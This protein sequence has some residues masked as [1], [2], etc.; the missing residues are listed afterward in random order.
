VDKTVYRTKIGWELVVLLMVV[1][2]P[3]V[4]M[5][6]FNPVSLYGLLALGGVAI[7]IAITAAKTTYTVEGENL[8]VKSGVF[9][10]KTISINTIRK[11]VETRNP[12][13][14]P[15]ASLDRIEI[16]YNKFDTIILSPKEKAEFLN[17]LLQINPQIEFVPRKK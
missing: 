12:L 15:A 13:S 7:V 14:S 11:V 16:F 9:Y 6:I 3:Q 8:T 17:H 10:N 4:V 2:V 1:L 5:A